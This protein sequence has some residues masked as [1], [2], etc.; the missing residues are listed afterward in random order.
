MQA[1]QQ[2][3]PPIWSDCPNCKSPMRAGK[4]GVCGRGVVAQQMVFPRGDFAA[5]TRKEFRPSAPPERMPGYSM[6]AGDAR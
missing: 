3:E 4:C 2:I 1:N 5:L 6:S